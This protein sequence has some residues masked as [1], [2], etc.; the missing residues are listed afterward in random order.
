MSIAISGILYIKVSGHA[1]GSDKENNVELSKLHY[2]MTH[3]YN[4]FHSIYIIKFLCVKKIDKMTFDAIS[5][6]LQIGPYGICMQ[7]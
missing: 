1:A 6:V 7:L 2:C 5:M 3:G 4:L